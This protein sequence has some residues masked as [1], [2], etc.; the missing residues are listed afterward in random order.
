[1]VVP[2]AC[3]LHAGYLRL[4][5][6]TEYVNFLPFHCIDVCTKALYLFV[7]R[8]LPVLLEYVAADENYALLGL[9]RSD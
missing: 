3:A 2:G 7:M 5:T 1:M 4:H 8:K 6:H 9:L